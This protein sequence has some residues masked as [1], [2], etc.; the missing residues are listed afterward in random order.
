[1]SEA[2]EPSPPATLLGLG[3]W[4]QQGPAMLV[5][6]QAGWVVLVPGLRK[7]IT[8]AAWTVLGEKP[9]P[10][11]FLERLVEVAD[12]DSADTLTAI[13]FGLLDGTTGTFGVKGKTPI[14]VYTPD[15]SHLVAGTED[16]PFVLRTFEGVRRTAFGDLPAEEP[17]G[18][19]RVS[20]GI[21]RVR[22]FV[23]VTVDPAEL[24]DESRVALADQVEA[25]GRSIADPE[26]AARR[27]NSSSSPAPPAASGGSSASMIRKPAVAGRKSG[28][29]PSSVSRGGSPSREAAPTAESAGPNMF[30]G[31]FSDPTPENPAP[32]AEPVSAM[33]ETTGPTSA[34]TTAGPASAV[35]APVTPDPPGVTAAPPEVTTPAAPVPAAPAP[36]APTVPPQKKAEGSR[37]RL[38]S[39]SLFDRKRRSAEPSDRRPDEATAAP[40][41]A[42]AGAD[43]SP[44]PAQPLTALPS[45][46]SSAPEASSAPEPG[47]ARAP[48]PESTAPVAP[49]PTRSAATP[50]P[51]PTV[52]I[53]T[54]DPP[55]DGDEELSSPVTQIAPIDDGDGEP[56][57]EEE[58]PAPAPTPAPRPAATGRRHAATELDNT[59]AYDDLFGKTVFRRIEDAA[60]RRAEADG[61]EDEAGEESQHSPSGGLA[62][63]S[64]AS[65]SSVAEPVQSEIDPPAEQPAPAAPANGGEFIDWVPGVG[66][67]APEIAQ[68][69]ARR[70]AQPSRPEPAYPQVNM[71]ERPP[72]PRPGPQPAPVRPDSGMHNG[73]VGPPHPHG[74]PMSTGYAGQQL[75]Y[76]AP[77]DASQQHRNGPVDPMAAANQVGFP[78]RQPTGGPAHLGRPAQNVGA[79]YDG[80]PPQHRGARHA[81]APHPVAPSGP[82][83]SPGGAPGPAARSGPLPGSSAPSTSGPGQPSGGAV[84]LSGLVCP[85]GHANSPERSTCRAC[86]SPLHGAPRT[87]ARPPLGAIEMSTGERIVLDRSAIIGRRPRASRVSGNDVPQLV[88]VPSPQQDISRSHLEL[89]LEGWHVVALDLGTTN[90]TT[91]YREGADPLRLRTREGVVLHEGDHLDLGDDVHLWMRERA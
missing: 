10:E 89:R 64:V 65:P 77:E 7:E 82:P 8:E 76:P 13:L 87:V 59:G 44:P 45:E 11:K 54:P 24:G 79:P 50:I 31:L 80:A 51:E 26:A 69:A 85:N 37:R 70:A 56:P 66:R 3:T 9:A 40:A 14:A 20:D 55:E 73:Q 63:S 52:S 15:G 25:H 27:E 1:M 30:A 35:S 18:A 57:Y 81:S 33:P 42:A 68:A 41:D 53:P 2:S 49:I 6:R 75:G 32:A 71:A 36:A 16:E 43:S 5:V 22:G 91:L 83:A 90:G 29:M 78:G 46:P 60:I 21:A 88:T 72:A 48:A 74:E 19:P 47:P 38:V 67:T 23:H 12:L 28:E 84:A 86:G 34:G 39:T 58:P 4:T 62:P 61:E 17:V